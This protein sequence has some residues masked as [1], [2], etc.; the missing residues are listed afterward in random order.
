M[1][2]HLS[3][4]H[5]H[6]FDVPNGISKLCDFNVDL[7]DEDNMLNMLGGDVENFGSVGYF[8]GYD[9]ALG[10]YCI[11]LVDK[12]RQILWNTFFVFSFDSL[13]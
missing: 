2:S 13:H 3:F 8:S 11:Y 5:E 4:S 10:P 9:V 6:S 7:G 1:F 12:P